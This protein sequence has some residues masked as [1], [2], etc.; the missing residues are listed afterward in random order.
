MPS[1][2]SDLCR[3]LEATSRWGSQHATSG[4]LHPSLIAGV[5]IACDECARNRSRPQPSPPYTL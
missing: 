1:Q 5:L 2:C 4:T 3:L